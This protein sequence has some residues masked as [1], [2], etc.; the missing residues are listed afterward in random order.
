MLTFAP[1]G[2]IAGDRARGNGDHF[3][4]VERATGRT[5]RLEEGGAR[6][7]LATLQFTDPAVGSMAVQVFPDGTITTDTGLRVWTSISEDILKGKRVRTRSVRVKRSRPGVREETLTVTLESNGA[8]CAQDE[9]VTKVQAAA[10][11]PVTASFSETARLASLDPA[12]FDVIGTD[13]AG[14]L[15][16]AEVTDWTLDR[17]MNCVGCGLGTIALV[18]TFA[19]LTVCTV[20]WPLL[21]MLPLEGAAWAYECGQCVGG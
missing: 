9:S 10:V 7:A 20:C 19:A 6:G 15:G 14:V 8:L 16:K 13:S 4:I 5:I 12:A 17:F 11:D 21:F 18:G 3:T 2:A 1:S